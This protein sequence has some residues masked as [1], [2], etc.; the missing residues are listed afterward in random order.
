MVA[1]GVMDTRMGGVPG[2]QLTNLRDG[3]GA[4]LQPPPPRLGYDV[5]SLPTLCCRGNQGEVADCRKDLQGPVVSL[6]TAGLVQSQTQTPFTS[7]AL[8]EYRC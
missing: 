4:K 7:T 8:L 1:V 2:L 5:S 3:G 6:A